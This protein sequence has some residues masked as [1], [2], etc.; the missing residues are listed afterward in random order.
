VTPVA[1]PPLRTLRLILE[2]DGTN[3][4]GWQVQRGKRTV[5][6]EVAK[7]VQRVTGERLTV[8][9]AGRTDAGVHAEGQSAHIVTRTRISAE[10]LSHALNAHLPPDIAVLR[11]DEAP[12]GFHAQFHAV[13]KTYRYRV[14]QRPVRSALRRDRAYLF[15]SPLDLDRMRGAAARLTGTHDFRAFCTEA[16]TR[17]R[18]ER[19]IDR[20]DVRR[21]GDEVV[22][23]VDGNGFLYNMVRT[24]VGTLLW[25]G[26]GKLTPDDVSAILAS[27]DRR[28]A[29]QV[30]PAQGLTLVEVRYA[31]GLRP[32]VGAGRGRNV[33]QE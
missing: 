4:A 13:G 1:P 21:E 25:V 23:E 33:A 28:R 12:G 3:F 18:T 11:V 16:S 27:K 20:L 31:D 6:G 8:H 7:A 9:G 5:Q 26:I 2:Y 15:R 10:R 19:R 24:I 14:L 32:P 17:G 22:F 30:I 29:G